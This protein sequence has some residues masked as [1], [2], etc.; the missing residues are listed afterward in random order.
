MSVRLH[1]CLCFTHMGNAQTSSEYWLKTR[2]QLMCAPCTEKHSDFGDTIIG[3]G[4]KVTVYT[5]DELE[6]F[7]GKVEKK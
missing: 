3:S 1:C 4:D 5:K 7:F 6:H 2:P